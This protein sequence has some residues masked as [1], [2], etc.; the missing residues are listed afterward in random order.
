MR[1]S[2]STTS[3]PA[4]RRSSTSVAFRSTWSRWPA[5]SSRASGG[6]RATTSSARAILKLGD[7]VG[8]ETV[9][10]GVQTAGQRDLLV[11]IGCLLGQG[12]FFAEP[13]AA[14][15]IGAMLDVPRLRVA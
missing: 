11:E 5:R 10:E 7:R 6:E 14:E 3:E 12:Y 8:I 15:H 4:T 1:A 2:P 13:L 9:A